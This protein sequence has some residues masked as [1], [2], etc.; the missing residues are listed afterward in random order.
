[1]KNRSLHL[2]LGL[3]VALAPSCF[4]SRSRLNQPLDQ[5]A[6]AQLVPGTSSAD[7]VLAA[8]GAP[9]D[10]VQLGRRVAWRYDHTQTKTAAFWPVVV[11]LSNS[12]TQQDRIWAF[13]DEAGLLTHIGGTFVADEAA[14]KMP[15]QDQE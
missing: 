7:D 9:N 4:V 3:L 15:W 10:V 14:Y 6:F 11:V 5:S 1:M 12:D 13:F 8:L 2:A